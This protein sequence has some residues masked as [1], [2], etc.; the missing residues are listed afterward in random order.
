MN[1]NKTTG[2]RGTQVEQELLDQW[3][4]RGFIVVEHLLSEDEVKDALKDVYQ[5]YMPT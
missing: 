1:S 3:R 5:H 4:R 2:P